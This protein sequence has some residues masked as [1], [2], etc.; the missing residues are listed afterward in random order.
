ML[1][2]RDTSFPTAT[3]LSALLNWV[4][5]EE[6]RKKG[7][8]DEARSRSNAAIPASAK[9]T[10][11][12]AANANTNTNANTTAT[13][14]ANANAQSLSVVSTPNPKILHHQRPPPHLY[15]RL[16]NGR[17][18]GNVLL[19]VVDSG[20]VS[21]VRVSEGCFAEEKVWM[22]NVGGVGGGK[23]GGKGVGARGG[24]GKGRGRGRGGR[25]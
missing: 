12:I 7:F 14:N 13:A 10:S 11:L 19:A 1:D 16:K 15:A 3:Q 2:A 4:L 6:K 22:G 17:A 25:G 18:G 23:G 20:L 8:V 5:V 24:K 21:Y 9:T